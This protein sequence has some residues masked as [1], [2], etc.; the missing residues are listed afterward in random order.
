MCV[1]LHLV[2]PPLNMVALTLS[3]TLESL[4]TWVNVALSCIR[5][6]LP[7]GRQTRLSENLPSNL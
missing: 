2:I 3:P 7:V 6:Q 5:G 1:S 4:Q